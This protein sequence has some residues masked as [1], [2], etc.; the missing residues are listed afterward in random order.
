MK[1]GLMQL[2][3]EPWECNLIITTVIKSSMKTVSKIISVESFCRQS[4]FCLNSFCDT[5]NLNKS[6]RFFKR[7]VA[8][9][10]TQPND[11]FRSDCRLWLI[12]RVVFDVGLS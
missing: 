2:P 4:Q 1:S 5:Q 3:S 11:L 9:A 6:W 12:N 7:D 8:L 10:G